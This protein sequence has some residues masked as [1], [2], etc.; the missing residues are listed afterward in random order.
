MSLSCEVHD[1]LNKQARTDLTA[2]A[3]EA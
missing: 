1:E 3:Y 2:D